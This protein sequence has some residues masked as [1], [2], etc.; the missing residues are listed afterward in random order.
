MNPLQPKKAFIISLIPGGHERDDIVEFLNFSIGK[1]KYDFNFQ[2][3][4]TGEYQQCRVF[5]QEDEAI[6]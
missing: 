5:I 6:K 4:H 3:E 2:L 1:G